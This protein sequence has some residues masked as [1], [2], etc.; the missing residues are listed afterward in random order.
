MTCPLYAIVHVY[1]EQVSFYK[2]PEKHVTVYE[3]HEKWLE[4]TQTTDELSFLYVLPEG[5]ALP[6]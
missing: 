4:E 3:K 1:T 5:I 6:F 2:V